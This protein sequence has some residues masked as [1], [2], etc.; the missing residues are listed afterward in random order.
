MGPC[1]S[2]WVLINLWLTGYVYLC[3]PPPTLKI[4][5]MPLELV[6]Q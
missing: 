5:P 2:A 3:P 1:V 4:V 6:I